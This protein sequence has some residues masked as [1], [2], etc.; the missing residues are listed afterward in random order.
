MYE[1]SSNSDSEEDKRSDPEVYQMRINSEDDSIVDAHKGK[2]GNEKLET[3]MDDTSLKNSDSVTTDHQDPTDKKKVFN[4]EEAKYPL[5]YHKY[6]R[7]RETSVENIIKKKRNCFGNFGISLFWEEKFLLLVRYLQL[8]SLCYIAFYEWWPFDFNEMLG[9]IVLG[10]GFNFVYLNDGYYKFIEEFEIYGLNIVGWFIVFAIFLASGVTVVRTKKLRHEFKHSKTLLKKW[11]F[12][13]SEILYAPILMNLIPMLTCSHKTIKNGYELHE[14]SE[15]GAKYYF[16]LFAFVMI[17][18]GI[19]YNVALVY[20]IR[21]RKISYRQKDH[22]GF[23]KRKELEYVLEISDSWR[24]QSFFVFSS[25]K[26]SKMRLYYKPV[27]NIFVLFL[28]CAHSFFESNLETKGNIFSVALI[29]GVIFSI[30]VRPFRCASS[31]F[32][33]LLQFMHLCGPVFM[34][35]QSIGG[36]QHGLLVNKYFSISLYI[37]LGVFGGGQLIVILL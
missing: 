2:D 24:K 12:N 3:P 11:L 16:M 8:Y 1:P 9:N 18:V 37:F 27:Y 25:F 29:A 31:N 4:I 6:L 22:D 32:L 5:E 13:I 19:F 23:M 26:G 10:L 7:C 34:V 15:Y 36:M 33:M 17:G 20:M 35:T 28:I 30:A 21:K 14:C